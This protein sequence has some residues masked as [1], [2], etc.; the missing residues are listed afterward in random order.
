MAL[1]EAIYWKMASGG[2]SDSF[3]LG[4]AVL[5]GMSIV[6]VYDTD[7]IYMPLWS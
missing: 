1:V 2:E 6:H 3:N 7:L 4:Y 5:G